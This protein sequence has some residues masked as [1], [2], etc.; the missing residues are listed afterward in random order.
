MSGPTNA[1]LDRWLAGGQRPV[2]LPSGT[3]FR[4]RIPDAE[5]LIIRGLVPS[6]L[7]EIAL[8]FG[9]SSV[10]PET[11]DTESLSLLLRFMRTMVAHSLKSIWSGPTSPQTFAELMAADAPWEPISVMLADLEEGTIDG[12]D[13]AALQGIATRKFTPEQITAYTLKERGRITKADAEAIAEAAVPETVRGWSSFRGEAG[14]PDPGGASAT[15]ERAPE[16][17]AR[18]PRSAARVPGR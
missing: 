15:V 10:T 4:I 13:Y 9:A 17:P 11:L 1:V 14:S 6:D 3:A 2:L 18:N 5:E 7:R 8:K 12:D 16:Q